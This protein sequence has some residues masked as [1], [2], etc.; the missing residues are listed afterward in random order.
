MISQDIK[1]RIKILTKRYPQRESALMPALM[2]AQRD[3][4]NTIDRELTAE[5]ANLVGVPESW[6]YGVLSY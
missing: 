4:E 2:L 3:N 6:G 5:V 1:D